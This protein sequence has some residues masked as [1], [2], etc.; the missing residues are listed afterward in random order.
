M[1]QRHEQKSNKS[2]VR[3]A[4]LSLFAAAV[5][6]GASATALAA[7]SWSPF[8]T[9]RNVEV[10]SWSSASNGTATYVWFTTPPNNVPSC[11]Q[12]QQQYL[13][14]GSV[15]NVKQMTA[16]ASQ[17]LLSG[18]PFQVHWTGNCTNGYAAFDSASIGW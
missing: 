9:L 2:V 13:A 10:D 17:A 1:N 15:D 11:G 4:A 8:G 16:L 6:V 14:S 5:I 12:G 3:K 7:G 18:K